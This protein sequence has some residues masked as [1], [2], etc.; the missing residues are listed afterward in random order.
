MPGIRVDGNDLLA[1]LRVLGE[2]MARA[3]SGG[4][5]TFVEALT[6]RMG[7]HSTSDDPSRYRSAVEVESWRR[8][9]PLDRLRR[10]LAHLGLVSD[11]GDVALERELAAEIAA[12][13]DAVEPMPPPAR[14]SL[15]DDVYA[16]QPWHLRE[17]LDQLQET[18]A[19]PTHG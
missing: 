10:H 3:R 14:D 18:Q 4:G 17:Q 11:A 2:A 12:A 1:M 5:P 19:A 16:E 15:L 9:D 6:Y 7:A 8:K 13:I